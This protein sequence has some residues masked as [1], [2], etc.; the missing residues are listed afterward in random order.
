MSSFRQLKAGTMN[1]RKC[2]VDTLKKMGYNPIIGKNQTVRG[3]QSYDNRNGYDIVLKK[4]D[5]A[6]RGDIGFQRG[7][8]GY[9]TVG[10]DSYIIRQFTPEQF[11]KK[12]QGEYT[13]TKARATAETLGLSLI[14]KQELVVGGRPI[15]RYQYE[16]VGA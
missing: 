14:G 15:I 3:D 10:M 9:Y 4:E 8:D 1:D 13:V 16:K 11:V 7:E 5:T 12:V 2:L 6:L